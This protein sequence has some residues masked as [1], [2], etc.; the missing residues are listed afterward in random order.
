MRL[1]YEWFIKTF[2]DVTAVIFCL[3]KGDSWVVA[4]SQTNGTC[5]EDFIT[6]AWLHKLFLWKGN[7][8]F[9]FFFPYHMGI[10]C[11]TD[12]AQIRES[13]SSFRFEPGLCPSCHDE[14][15]LRLCDDAGGLLHRRGRGTARLF[16]TLA[17]FS[18]LCD[19]WRPT[20]SKQ[21]WE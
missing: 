17:V 12:R 18:C 15:R 20:Q 13:M 2:T 5:W 9:L 3:L 19:L 1:Y 6:K 14:F 16:G 11:R 7:Q 8:I 21:V 10:A 4:Q